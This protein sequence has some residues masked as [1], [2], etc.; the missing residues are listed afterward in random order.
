MILLDQDAPLILSITIT[1]AG[2]T[3]DNS[4]PV[5]SLIQIEVTA[6][7][8]EDGLVGTVKIKDPN[9]VERS[10]SIQLSGQ[11][12]GVYTATWDSRGS[13][14]GLY[15]AEVSL[16]DARRRRRQKPRSPFIHF[17]TAAHQTSSSQ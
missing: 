6:G 15:S 7:G 14:P 2:E 10:G 12:S 13:V 9:G 4:Y 17:T 16:R 3:A 1:V 8:Q 11:G 5:N